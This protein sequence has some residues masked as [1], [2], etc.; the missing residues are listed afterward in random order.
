LKRLVVRGASLQDYR[1]YRLSGTR[2][3]EAIT[4]YCHDD[5]EAMVRARALPGRLELWRRERLIATLEGGE[6]GGT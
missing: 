1:V 2:I 3:I 5:A 4:L 6:S